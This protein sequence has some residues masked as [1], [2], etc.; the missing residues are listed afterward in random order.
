MIAANSAV[1][2]VPLDVV[3]TNNSGTITTG[4]SFQTVAALNSSRKGCAVQNPVS[5][6]EN[7]MVNFGTLGSATVSNSFSLA[8]GGAINCSNANGTVLEDAIN[9]EAATTGHAFVLLV[10]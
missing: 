8:P 4:G 2:P 3:S 1:T 10:Q 6:T 7:L 5:A 9:V